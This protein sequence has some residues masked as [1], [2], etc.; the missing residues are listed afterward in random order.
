MAEN[1]ANVKLSPHTLQNGQSRYIEVE[2]S[3]ENRLLNE[4][5]PRTAYVRSNSETEITTV[6]YGQRQLLINE[7]EFLTLC[8]S[9]LSQENAENSE[10][11]NKKFVAFYA[12]AAPGHHLLVLSELF[13]F[14]KFILVDPLKLDLIYGN[15]SF[16]NNLV[17][18]NE[19]FTEHLAQE[20]F[21]RYQEDSKF[22]RLFISDIRGTK[23]DES[24]IAQEMDLQATIHTILKPYKSYLK[25][26]LPYVDD[27]N[28][29]NSVLE[30]TYLSGDVYFLIWGRAHTSETRL[31]VHKDSVERTYDCVK[32][33]DQLFHFNSNERTFCYEHNLTVPGFD[34]CYDCRA[35][36]YVFEK[37]LEIYDILNSMKPIDRRNSAEYV[38]FVN[39]QLRSSERKIPFNFIIDDSIFKGK[40]KFTRVNYGLLLENENDLREFLE[41]SVKK[42]RLRRQNDLVSGI[43]GLN[44][45]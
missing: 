31:L 28:D 13:P 35:E 10:W 9:G 22:I 40:Y 6:H 15:G 7:I 36:L 8:I 14:V 17:F 26:R 24:I 33:Q 18:I 41:R 29:P 5:S 44:L 11:Q 39:E 19:K 25:F 45:E 3:I 37:Y 34:H 12:G 23:D 43:Q 20:L 4:N 2:F 42:F 32:Y 21:T 38:R 16:K 1:I 27:L 30:K